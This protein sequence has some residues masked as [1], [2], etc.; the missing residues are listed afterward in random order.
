[1]ASKALDV[2]GA[3]D[4]KLLGFVQGFQQNLNQL[5][6]N[7]R[8]IGD[9]VYTNNVHA[10]VLRE[11]MYEKGLVTPEDYEAKIN[12]ELHVRDEIQKKQAEEAKAVAE[13][14]KKKQA[15]EAA[16]RIA[17]A[18]ASEE[19]VEPKIFGGDFKEE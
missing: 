1:M 17:P 19:R 8:V 9:M 10:T 12:H 14:L 5:Y 13:E 18:P 2:V 11:I 16:A 6:T 15:E 4:Q 7:I 3:I